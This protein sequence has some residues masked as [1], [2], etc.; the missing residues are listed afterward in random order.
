MRRIPA[1]A[2]RAW[3]WRHAVDAVA[4][5]AV[6][7]LVAPACGGSDGGP[8]GN[9]SDA[10]GKSDGG[11]GGAGAAASGGGGG[12]IG[13][14]A[15][16]GGGSGGASAT[17]GAAAAMDASVGAPAPIG[18]ACAKD[19]DCGGRGLRCLL[20]SGAEIGGSG[21]A[22]GLCTADCSADLSSTSMQSACAAFD[23]SATCL[24][25]TAT[26]AYCAESCALGP[27]ATG[28]SKCHGRHDMACVDATGVGLG[29]CQPVC[30][31]DADCGGRKCNLAA[32]VCADATSVTGT[33]PIGTSCDLHL[34]TTTCKGGCAGLLSVGAAARV[35]GFCSGLSRPRPAA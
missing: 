21:I 7:G 33:D 4:L 32:G 34:A 22:G 8:S 12:A 27:V 13:S 5:I 29:Y 24:R 2:S 11:S 31:G 14:G 9:P 10:S 3:V 16:A 23:P 1:R 15:T 19:S 35:S 18:K 25:V 30:R 26:T 28:G 17:G 6:V 20:P